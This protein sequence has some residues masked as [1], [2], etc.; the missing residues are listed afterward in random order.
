MFGSESGPVLVHQSLDCF[1]VVVVCGC[2]SYFFGRRAGCGLL[3]HWSFVCACVPFMEPDLFVL[4]D[5][6]C[7][8]ASFSQFF[9]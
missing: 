7:G 1:V 3:I 9:V 8:V 4:I 5:N 6:V 2:E